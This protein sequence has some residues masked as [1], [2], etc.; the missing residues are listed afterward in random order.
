MEAIICAAGRSPR[1][2]TPPPLAGASHGQE[3]DPVR[4]EAI[5]RAA[6]RS[7]RQRTTLYGR[8]AAEQER[9]SVSEEGLRGMQ[10][11]G[12]SGPRAALV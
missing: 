2:R 12:F 1:Q 9:R 5:I 3:L 4:M 6:G 7:P 10:P 11:L 8:P